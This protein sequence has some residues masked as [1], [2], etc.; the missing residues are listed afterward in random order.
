MKSSRSFL[1]LC[2][3]GVLFGCSSKPDVG[4][5]EEQITDA[6]ALCKV[7]KVV[8]LEKTNGVDR[9]DSYDMG[10]SYGLEA[11]RDVSIN[12]FYKND[13]AC[14]GDAGGIGMGMLFIQSA[15]KDGK[16]LDALIKKGDIVN[17]NTTFNMVNSENGWIQQ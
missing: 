11:L 8:N 5:V 15:V 13:T 14:S 6:W 10:I 17:V 16:A 3:T 1:V 2:L 7:L 12:E 9:G 4:D